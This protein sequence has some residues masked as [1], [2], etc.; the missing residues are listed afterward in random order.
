MLK[1]LY[2]NST[3]FDCNVQIP[4]FYGIKVFCFMDRFN[5]GLITSKFDFLAFEVD[6]MAITLSLTLLNSISI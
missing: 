5:L 1:L 6:L 4:L 3:Q 2:L